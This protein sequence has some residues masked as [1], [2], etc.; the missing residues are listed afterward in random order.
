M[1]YKFLILL[2]LGISFITEAQTNDTLNNN[3]II[4][5]SKIGLPPTTIV[6]KIQNS[7][8]NFD[9]SIDALIKLK[10]EG[11]DGSVINEMINTSGKAEKDNQKAASE[12]KDMS[13]PKTMRKPGIYYFKA[14]GNQFT[15]VDPT[16]MSTTK[17]GGFGSALAQHYTYGIAK[18]KVKSSL[19]GSNSRRQIM[20]TKPTFFFYFQE[21]GNDNM[22]HGAANWWFATATSP[23]EFALVKCNEK[24][25][26]REIEVGESN[27]YGSQTGINEKQKIAFDYEQI[28]EGVYKV[29]PK[30][31]LEK[32][33][34]CFIY[35][36]AIPTAG[37]YLNDKVFDFGIQNQ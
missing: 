5:L 17:S 27:Y 20:E 34:Y 19:G 9:V 33:E 6:S 7:K 15:P 11:V 16:V 18:S 25:A 30:F 3:S 31:Q 12:K 22:M 29:V 26:S 13:D 1:K 32:G 36:G 8:T 2:L 14:E 21:N 37:G 10:N 24:D 4:Q 28:A 35:T 23:N